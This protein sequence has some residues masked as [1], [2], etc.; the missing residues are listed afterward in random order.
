MKRA[1]IVLCG[2]E[3]LRMG[4]AKAWLP[5]GPER[6]LQRVVRL[7]RQAAP[8]V[9]VV[10]AAGQDLP[11]LAGAADVVRDRRPG[12]GP[13]EGL[14]SGLI[15]LGA[16]AEAAYVTSC[17]CPLLVP[18]FIDRMFA[19][20][21]SHDIAVPQDGKY[22]HPLAAVY[23]ASV[24]PQIERLLAADRLRPAHLF[25]VTDTLA[26][27]VDTLR[28]VDPDLATLKNVNRPADYAEALARAGLRD[29]R[30]E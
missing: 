3:S 16:R 26:V 12:R 11:E 8:A 9:V 27:P 13:L 18:A 10:A 20:V 24:L 5:F 6:M 15:A 22:H 23:R 25:E 28:D 7:A 1:A 21:E 19:L 30:D 17:D 4:R 29:S 14:A 2:G